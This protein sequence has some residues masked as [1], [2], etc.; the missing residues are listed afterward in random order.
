MQSHGN[1]NFL[2]SGRVES[3]VSTQAIWDSPILG[4]GSWARDAKYSAMLVERLQE[5]GYEVEGNRNEK[6]LIPSHSYLLGSWVEAG[7]GGGLFWVY[8]LWLGTAAFYRTLAGAEPYTPLIVFT[9]LFLVWEIL[10]SP[11][12]Q[13]QRV[14]AALHICLVLWALR[15]P[16]G[17]YILPAQPQASASARHE[18]DSAG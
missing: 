10:F 1:L 2:Q 7:L 6:D 13:E 11:F 18:T 5:S 9:I 4:H 8:V 14:V 3:L 16:S 15:P 12:A 17:Q